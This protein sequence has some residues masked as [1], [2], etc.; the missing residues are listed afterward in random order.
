MAG[1]S[2][3]KGIVVVTGSLETTD[4]A[5]LDSRSFAPDLASGLDILKALDKT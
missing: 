4:F 5:Q 1:P 3:A 2:P